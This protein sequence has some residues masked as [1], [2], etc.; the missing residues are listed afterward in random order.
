MEQQT[1]LSALS[2]TQIDPEVFRRVWNRVMPDQ[3]HSPIQVSSPTPSASRPQPVQQAVRPA[4]S[5]AEIIRNRIEQ[6]REGALRLQVLFRRMNGRPG[7]R[8]ISELAA[9]HRQLLRQLTTAYF[10][11]TGRRFQPG[12][13]TP[14]VDPDLSLAL[15]EQFLWAQAWT[16]DSLQAAQQCTEA[17]LRTLCGQLAQTGELHAQTIRALLERTQF[18]A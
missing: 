5:D 14:T 13:M 9:G 2:G 3:E 8:V 17:G 12:G 11:T 6:A 15:R 1:D 4:L 16:R 10:L 18:N 7:A